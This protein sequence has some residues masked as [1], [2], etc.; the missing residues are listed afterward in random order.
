MTR[1]SIGVQTLDPSLLA[2]LGRRATRE[3]N[4]AA[5][6][7]LRRRWK[8]DLSVDLLAGIP[9]QTWQRLSR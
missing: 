3:Q 6:D 2:L 1:I 8:G 4:L 7:L 5:L 9:G